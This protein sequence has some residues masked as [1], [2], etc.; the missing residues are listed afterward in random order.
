MLFLLH[1]A[2][3]LLKTKEVSSL[4][5]TMIDAGKPKSPWNILQF[6]AYAGL[7]VTLLAFVQ[8]KRL[9]KE[10]VSHSQSLDQKA[11]GPASSKVGT[12]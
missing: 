12:K 5:I 7:H 11:S 8:M 1:F 3:E 4:V 6:L 9:L 10:V 2:L